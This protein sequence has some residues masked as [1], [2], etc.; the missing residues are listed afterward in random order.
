MF[1]QNKEY[2]K[3]WY[4][5]DYISKTVSKGLVVRVRVSVTSFQSRILVQDIASMCQDLL[6]VLEKKK[7]KEK[8]RNEIKISW[9]RVFF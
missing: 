3:K 4:K 7:I 9:K 8:E 1:F 6:F 5:S 2:T